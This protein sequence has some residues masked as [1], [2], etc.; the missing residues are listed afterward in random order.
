MFGYLRLILAFLVLLSHLDIRISGL[1]PGV[2]AVVIFYILA[3]FVVSR[4]YTQ[5]LPD[6]RYKLLLFYKDRALRIFPLYL[7]VLTLTL[8]FLLVTSYANPDFSPLKILSN[9]AVIP[10]NYYMYLDSTVLTAPAWWLIPPAW[11]LGTELQA[12]LLFPLVLLFKRVRLLL[13]LLSLVIYIAAN[14]SLLHPDHFGYRFL[15]GVLFIFIAGSAL[16]RGSTRSCDRFERFFPLFVWTLILCLLPLFA[17][18]DAFSPT[19]TK[20]TFAGLLI[21]LPLVFALARTPYR[22]PFDKTLG[23]LSYAIFLTHF[24]SIWILDCLNLTPDS[25]PTNALYVTLLSLLLSALGLHFEK[26]IRPRANP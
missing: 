18:M 6:T 13:A 12:Y 5:I 21:G 14:L 8:V 2:I 7:F 19:Y 22:L 9:I 3:G 16:H 4:L 10:L 17:Y 23:A 11:S 25:T 15:A 24:L 26:K 1:N 20:E